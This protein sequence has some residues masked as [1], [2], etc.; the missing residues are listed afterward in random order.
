MRRLLYLG[1]PVAVLA[2]LT[3]HPS[4]A[5]SLRG[6]HHSVA[7]STANNTDP[8]AITV[9]YSQH[10]DFGQVSFV[11]GDLLTPEVHAVP[12]GLELTLITPDPPRIIEQ[13]KTREV[14]ALESRAQTGSFVIR[15]RLACACGT[16]WF[17]EGKR[18][19]LLLKDAPKAARADVPKAARADVP[20]ATSTAVAKTTSAVVAKT[21]SPVSSSASQTRNE[22][23]QLRESLAAKLGLLSEPAPGTRS[24]QPSQSPSPSL[25]VAIQPNV[26]PS[27]HRPA[28]AAD[29]DTS[30]WKGPEGSFRETL[31]AL[32]RAAADSSEGAPEMAALTEFYLAYGLAGEAQDTARTALNGE[33]AEPARARLL[34]DAEVAALLRGESIGAASPLLGDR[35]DCERPDIALWRALAAANEQDPVGVVRDVRAART[36]LSA[37]PEPLLR[38]FAFRL[39]NAAGDNV[40]ALRDMAAALRNASMVSPEDE[41]ARFLLQARISRSGGD[42]DGEVSFLERAA[43]RDLTVPGLVAAERLA[44][45]KSTKDDEAGAHSEA[46]LAD[47]A[48]VYRGL[49]LGQSAATALADRHVRH[50]NYVSA[51]AVADE[52][53]SP[54]GIR[55]TDSRGA[56]L[57]VRV[58]RLLFVE[59]TGA[60]LPDPSER[61]ALYLKYDGYATPG[62]TGDSIRLGAAK[63]MLGE[64]MASSA[65]DVLHQLS[66][67]VAST[68]QGKT[69]RAEAEALAG[70]PA[71]SMLL[72]HDLPVSPDTQRVSS[73]ALERMG[74]PS[75]AAHQLDGLMSIADRT[76]RAALLCHAK[77]WGEAAA[78]Y[79]D[80]LRDPALTAEV[81]QEIADR[82]GFAVALSG[83]KPDRTLPHVEGGLAARTLA[84][85]APKASPGT[86]AGT[87][88]PL[89]L[90]A[91]QGALERAKQVETLL[92]QSGSNQGS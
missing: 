45:L 10:D 13:N 58:L 73:D 47:M 23:A 5:K 83:S 36:A 91:M 40:S 71:V 30:H 49:K 2:C 25:P 3:C 35:P 51:L 79:A 78:A 59:P 90:G 6:H 67:E 44:E 7:A 20:K 1:C 39:A 29:F 46:V 61:I 18:F 75:D 66:D 64:D 82:Y 55:G 14:L 31:M 17:R 4:T 88:T 15:V 50:A 65:L 38:A 12:G 69:V 81:R 22:I 86:P 57:M 52:S 11:I 87:R 68:P 74:R 8:N 54:N 42:P 33:V 70:D 43:R 72:L 21:S 92:P 19:T 48:R 24:A 53:A 80:L 62:Q 77:A 32:R 28:C 41:A 34:R 27:V 63:L 85:L 84:A 76:R 37:L 26:A 60:N 89:S 56:A 16:N 9:V